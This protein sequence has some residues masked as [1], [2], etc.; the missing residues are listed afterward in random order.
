MQLAHANTD[1]EQIS[2]DV[3]SSPR[4]KL[5]LADDT[6]TVAIPKEY[7]NI[8]VIFIRVTAVTANINN[9]WFK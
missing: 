1:C 4:Q 3:H 8:L 6:R 7:N 5:N 2:E 9:A